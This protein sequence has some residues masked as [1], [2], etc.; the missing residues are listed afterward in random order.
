MEVAGLESAHIYRP[1]KKARTFFAV[2]GCLSVVAGI[3]LLSR[4][5]PDCLI[6]LSNES[7]AHQPLMASSFMVVV[8]FFLV[9]SGVLQVR[10]YWKRILV[11]GPERVEVEF[12][13]GLR[14][15]EYAAIPGAALKSDT[16][17]ELYCARPQGEGA[18]QDGDQRRLFDRRLLPGL[19]FIASRSRCYRQ[20]E[21]QSRR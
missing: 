10:V 6:A 14:S 19:D 16:I 11:L 21:S 5:V 2:M 17:W 8:G 1:S 3:W 7:A 18:A 12:I 9:V 15:M 4:C 20:R 13:Y